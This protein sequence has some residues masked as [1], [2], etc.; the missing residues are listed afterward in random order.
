MAVNA[1]VYHK[2]SLQDHF[3]D[4]NAMAVLIPRAYEW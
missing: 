1:Q 4:H 2:K 3:S